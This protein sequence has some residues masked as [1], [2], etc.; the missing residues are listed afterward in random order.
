MF[1]SDGI[2]PLNLLST[3]N[4]PLISFG[5]CSSEVNDLHP[6]QLNH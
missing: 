3:F 1:I 5:K 6:V 2:F 4:T